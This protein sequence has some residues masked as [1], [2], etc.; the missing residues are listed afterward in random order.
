MYSNNGNSPTNGGGYHNNQGSLSR[1]GTPQNS[2]PRSS[3][4]QQ[5]Q[6]AGN[7]SELDSLLQDLSSA[8]YGSNLDKQH[9]QQQQHPQH[10]QQIGYNGTSSPSQMNT[11]IDSYKRPSV[12]SLLDELSNANS[13]GPIYAVPNG[14]LYNFFL[15]LFDF[16]FIKAFFNLRVTPG[17]A[18]NPSGGKHV[19]ITV[20]ETKTERLTPVNQGKFEFQRIRN[21]IH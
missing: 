17:V 2:L 16:L 14:Y 12:D 3:T 7:L 8:R 6:N 20:R 10:P 19:T 11:L 1:T 5:Q 4:A 15:F 18:K 13:T 9:H 21:I